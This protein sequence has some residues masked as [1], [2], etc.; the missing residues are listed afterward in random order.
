MKI[1]KGLKIIMAITFMVAII[2]TIAINFVYSSD[3]KKD[4]Y[5]LNK[6][7]LNGETVEMPLSINLA[8][9]EE[10]LV[11]ERNILDVNVSKKHLLLSVKY[12]AVKVYVD[13]KL[14]YESDEPIYRMKSAG[15]ESK[16]ID[17][18]ELK[19][20]SV[21]RVELTPYLE[22]NYAANIDTPLLGNTMSILNYVFTN[23]LFDI[24]MEA[25][26]FIMGIILLAIHFLMKK[27]ESSK[28]D[29]WL[30]GILSI[31]CGGYTL[32]QM[33][34]I[35][36]VITNSYFLYYIEFVFLMLIPLVV[37]QLII[38]NVSV[39][40]KK[41]FLLLHVIL[42]ANFIFQHIAHFILRIEFREL[43]LLTH[44]CIIMV[45]LAF[46]CA[47]IMNIKAMT[48]QN[49]ETVLSMIPALIGGSIDLS[50]SYLGF[51]SK[52][53][54][55]YYFKIGLF[56]FIGMQV[57]YN[58]QRFIYNLN[59][60][61]KAETYRQL[62]YTDALTKLNNRLAF[63]TDLKLIND[64]V[65][66]KATC[67]SIDINDLKI[68]NDNMGHEK[69]DELII[70]IATVLQ[71]AVKEDGRIYRI[72]GDEF[73]VLTSLEEDEIKHLLNRIDE[74][75]K[76]EQLNHD[77][78][79]SY[80]IGYSAYQQSDENAEKMIARADK[81]MYDDKFIYKQKRAGI[82]LG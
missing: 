80:A 47:I 25:S 67:I 72:G 26:L 8:D 27:E 16:I 39:K 12:N 5:E 22:N 10:K 77:F 34:F 53:Y 31:V 75:C 44:I 57:Y 59:E 19:N 78:N 28:L 24:L 29:F 15:V 60:R 38:K 66:V 48:K 49:K 82:S 51:T 55:A 11:I 13:D 81:K 79:I 61:L 14:A 64:N 69:G 32:V 36:L 4:I 43:I 2:F 21:I 73:I 9:D 46:A 76:R 33:P 6:W 37:V 58:Y 40:M 42:I 18:S 45:V 30:L 50:L 52:Y 70:S 23:N 35:R 63:E 17:L 71:K 7:Q 62:A 1:N 54:S 68:V 65:G 56:I 74:E 41:V 20:N 3:L